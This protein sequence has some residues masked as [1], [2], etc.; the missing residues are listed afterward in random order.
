MKETLLQK[1]ARAGDG[2]E[3]VVVR[4]DSV[5]SLRAAKTRQ[6]NA[7]HLLKQNKKAN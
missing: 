4:V 6:N 3:Y 7:Q 5:V 2:V 1:I